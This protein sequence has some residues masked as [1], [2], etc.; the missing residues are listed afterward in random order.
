LSAIVAY[1]AGIELFGLENEFFLILS[2][3]AIDRHHS[4]V[5]NVVSTIQN[6]DENDKERLI[7]QAKAINYEDINQTF[8]SLQNDIPFD[9]SPILS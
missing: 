3:I 1:I 7:K 8:T 5:D 2:L 4:N 6:F 9:L